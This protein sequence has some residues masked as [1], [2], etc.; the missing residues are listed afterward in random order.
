[1]IVQEG[2]SRRNTSSA[3]QSKSQKV[4]FAIKSNVLGNFI[5]KDKY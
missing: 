5:V 2:G 1:M 4:Q 3:E